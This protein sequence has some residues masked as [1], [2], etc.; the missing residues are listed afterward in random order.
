MNTTAIDSHLQ[1]APLVSVVLCTYNGAAYLEEQ[2]NSLLA[3]TYPNLEIVILDDCS[4]DNTLPLLEK[5]A[6]T[7][8]HIIV[9][10]NEHNLGYN[11]NYEKAIQLAKGEYIAIADQDD[12]WDLQKISFMM[13][14]LWDSHTVLVHCASAR[15]ET[16]Q[17]PKLKS[18]TYKKAFTGNDTRSFFLY[19]L[20]SGHNIIFKKTLLPHILPFPDNIFYDWWLCAAAT[21][22]GKIN[23][24]NK[25]LVYQRMHA[26]NAT[27]NVEKT[28]FFYQ[29]TIHNLQAFLAMPQLNPAYALLGKQLLQGFSTLAN[30][31]FSFSLFAGIVKYSPVLFSHKKRA[32]PWISY[33][34]HAFIISHAKHKV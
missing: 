30:R 22:V 11:K 14:N 23:G 31:A 25:V 24:T 33:I 3:Q 16:N 8:N 12:I 17:A 26:H 19:S 13:E 20:I 10:Q 34:K 21:T 29:Q 15:F 18:S 5:M 6:A 9:Y 27:V 4:T 1:Q 32:F 2:M 28:S 7:N